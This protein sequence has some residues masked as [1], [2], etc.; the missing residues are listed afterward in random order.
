MSWW[1][2]GYIEAGAGGS[3][4]P[5]LPFVFQDATKAQAVKDAGAKLLAGP[6][7]T[8]D[9]AQ[10]WANAYEKNPSTLHA[11]S[12]LSPSTGTV[13]GDKAP[14][15]AAGLLTGLNAIGDFFAR[16]S[17]GNTWLRLGEGLLGIILIAVGLARITSA[18]PAAT[19]IA[20]TVGA[21]GVAA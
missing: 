6:F 4:T 19:R 18:V 2:G 12:G 5:Y 10:N 7:A 1:V 11:G 20:K 21:T 17:E 16:L 9:D 13:Q 14:A 15:G 3:G 8:Q